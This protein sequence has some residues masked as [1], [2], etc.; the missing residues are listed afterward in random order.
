MSS[1]TMPEE[2]IG[3]PLWVPNQYNYFLVEE[4]SMPNGDPALVINGAVSDTYKAFMRAPVL[5]PHNIFHVGDT[6]VGRAWSMSC[7]LKLTNLGASGTGRTM[8]GV[9]TRALTTFPTSNDNN[10]D[11]ILLVGPSGTS[12]F[13]TYRPA[14]N[15]VASPNTSKVL[16]PNHATAWNLFQDYWHLFVYTVSQDGVVG[17]YNTNANVYLDTY[18]SISQDGAGGSAAAGAFGTPAYLH[19]GA[20]GSG[21]LGRPDQWRMAKWAFHDHVLSTAERIALWQEMYGSSILYTDN[22]DRASLGPNWVVITGANAPDIASDQLRGQ[23]T[24]NRAIVLVRDL[25]SADHYSQ[26]VAHQIG[27]SVHCAVR[28]QPYGTAFSTTQPYT[29]GYGGT[30]YE[31]KRGSSTVLASLVEAPP[32]TPFTLRLEAETNG[33]GNVDLRLYAN[34]VLKLSFTDSSGSKLLGYSNCGI[35]LVGNTTGP[36]PALADDFEC[37]TL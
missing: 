18:W 35:L 29:G 7:W 9:S 23:N 12:G 36:V 28:C 31:I 15:N 21:M 37:G 6:L 20:Y 5:S 22:F 34:G 14:L 32:S 13:Q 10:G 4:N 33:S 24:T 8:F 27:N 16:T 1:F 19:I 25:G 26:I 2:I 17:T 3:I 11:A 30:Q